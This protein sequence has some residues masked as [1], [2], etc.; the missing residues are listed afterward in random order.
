MK[1]AR[2]TEG[3]EP[4]PAICEQSGMTFVEGG[5]QITVELSFCCGFK[6]EDMLNAHADQRFEGGKIEWDDVP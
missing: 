5:R 6:S 2:I 3:S 1:T 4:V